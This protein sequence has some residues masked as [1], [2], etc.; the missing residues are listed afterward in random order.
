MISRGEV[1][2]ITAGLGLQA[3]VLSETLFSATVIIVLVTTLVTPV[4]LRLVLIR[5]L[6]P[7]PELVANGFS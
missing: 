2:L 6:E 1:A 3:H 7:A 5:T 4:L